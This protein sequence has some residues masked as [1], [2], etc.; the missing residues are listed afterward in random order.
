MDRMMMRR[1]V[2]EG[3]DLLERTEKLWKEIVIESHFSI[4]I[5]MA[6]IISLSITFSTLTLL[7]CVAILNR[8]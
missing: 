2:I 5:T 6:I 1:K 8:I 7:I 3:G 4:I